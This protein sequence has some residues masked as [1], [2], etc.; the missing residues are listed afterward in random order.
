MAGNVRAIGVDVGTSS[1]K[2]VAI[3]EHGE[4]LGEATRSYPVDMPH[5]G[6]SEQNPDDWVAA[7]KA[8]L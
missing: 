6:W 2:G 5:P 1:T 8:V 7:T 4:L 3:D